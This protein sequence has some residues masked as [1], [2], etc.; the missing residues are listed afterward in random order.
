MHEALHAL[1]PIG[2]RAKPL[3]L[4]TASGLPLAELS[5]MDEAL[6]R[7]HSNPLVKAGM[8]MGE[9]KGLIV[10]EDELLDPPPH[11]DAETTPMDIVRQTYI[12]LNEA[13]AVGFK[14]Y[15]SWP[16]CNAEFGLA[17]LQMASLSSGAVDVVRFKG[18]AT[19]AF[20]LSNPFGAQGT[21]YWRTIDGAWQQVTYSNIWDG[22]PW[23]DGFS[24]PSTLLASVLLL[25]DPEK[26][27]ISELEQGKL[28]LDVYL[29]KTW[30]QISW[31]SDTRL[32]ANFTLDAESHEI[33]SYFMS[34][35]FKPDSEDSCT[36]YSSKATN[37]DYGI[38]IEIPPVIQRDSVILRWLRQQDS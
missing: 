26:I 5:P 18:R 12:A 32:T 14:I 21:E 34:W 22:T 35:R 29:E 6:I 30:L 37:G 11:V 13:E 19:N 7:L 15:G 33:L 27:K 28:R 36:S 17:D 20:I 1:V 10:F 31:S 23:R 38:E 8:N 9:V 16:G 4:M 24:N 3:S 2:H 25:A